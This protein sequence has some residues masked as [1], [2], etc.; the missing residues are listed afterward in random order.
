M[1][2]WVAVLLLLGLL[3]IQRDREHYVE[4]SAGKRPDNTTIWAGTVDRPDRTSSWLSKI[5]AAAP[6]GGNDDDYLRVLQSFYDTVWKPLRDKDATAS[7]RD[8]DVEVFMQSA[9]AQVPGVDP[10]AIRKIIVAGFSVEQTSS[11]AAREEQQIKFKPSQSLEPRDG[12]DQVYNRKESIY[13]PVDSR[14]GELPEG[15]YPQVFQQDTPRREGTYDD[16]SSGWTS[17]QFY[18]LST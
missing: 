13:T 3:W 16:K 5:D 18:G 11:A 17:V 1:V 4:V 14:V 10:N 15:I 7:V 6:I 2:V 8:T 9:G 12:I